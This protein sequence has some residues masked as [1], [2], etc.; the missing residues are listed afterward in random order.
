MIKHGTDIADRIGAKS[1]LE[2]TSKGLGLYLR[3]GWK[4]VDEM[5]VD[6]KPYGGKGIEVTKFMIRDP[7]SYQAV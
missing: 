2:S 4:V 5:T 7:Q 1:Y 6:M 3:H